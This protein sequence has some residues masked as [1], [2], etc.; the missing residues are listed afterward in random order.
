MIT[1]AFLKSILHYDPATGVFTWLKRADARPQWNGRYAGTQAGCLWSPDGTTTYVVINIQHRPIG[2]HRLAVL[3]MTGEW[4]EHGVDHR[5][6]DGTNN[7]WVN[8]R[9]ATQTQNGRNR[10]VSKR[11][12]SGLKGAYKCKNGRWRSQLRIDGRLQSL[13]SYDSKEEAHAAYAAAIAQHHGEF[14][15]TS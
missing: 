14:A 9:P 5:D 15:R 4:P 7:R 8:L 11:S 1:Q 12:S 3:Y 10:G 6:L 2:A 13:G